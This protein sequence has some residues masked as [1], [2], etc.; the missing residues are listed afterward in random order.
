MLHLNNFVIIFLLILIYLFFKPGILVFFVIMDIG[1]ILITLMDLM[2]TELHPSNL[3]KNFEP[4]KLKII[5]NILLISFILKE[6]KNCITLKK[7]RK[8][9]SQIQV[10]GK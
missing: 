7:Q 2:N 10:R 5:Q 8:I 1:V 3:I 9:T 4:N 6:E